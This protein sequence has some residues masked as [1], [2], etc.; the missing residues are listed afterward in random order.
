[1]ELLTRRKI[2][3]LSL[4]VLAT[5]ITAGSA[6]AAT[7][8]GDGTLVGT[9]GNDKLN[10]GQG[11]DSVWGLGGSDTINAGNGNDMIDGGGHCPQGDQGQDFPN[12][13]PGSN[14][15]A[16][17]N[18]GNQNGQETITAGN[19]N[20]TVFGGGGRNMISV[21]AGMDTIYGGP[22]GDTINVTAGNSSDTINLCGTPHTAVACASG[23]AGST[24]NLV[25]GA[26]GGVVFADNGKKDTINCFGSPATVFVDRR[27]DTVNR[28]PHVVRVAADP[29]KH[30]K[31]HGG[32][33]KKRTE[34]GRRGVHK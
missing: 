13:I 3:A 14:Q 9:P 28:C 23:Y 18:Q 32:K 20:D 11:N 4:L 16:H 27:L 7:V 26:V 24:V 12:G 19:G 22:T 31:A 15:C 6:L 17:G 34:K 5:A 25:G 21:G 10:A 2:A 33:R 30:R 29:R 1:M 8:G